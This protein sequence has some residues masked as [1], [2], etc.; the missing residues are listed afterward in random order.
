MSWNCLEEDKVEWLE[1]LRVALSLMPSNSFRYS[2]SLVLNLSRF[3]SLIMTLYRML[4]MYLDSIGGNIV[5]SYPSHCKC[6]LQ[7]L[8]EIII[9]CVCEHN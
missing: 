4:N 8:N 7:G 6:L 9:E 5:V 3:I 2:W 1:I